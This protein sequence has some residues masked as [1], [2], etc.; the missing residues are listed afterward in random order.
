[1]P[2]DQTTTAS[3][4]TLLVVDDEPSIAKYMGLVLMREGYHVL[5]AFNAEEGWEI[6]Q[7]ATP[8]VRAVV[9][10][11]AMPGD[12]NGLELARRVR[13]ASPATPVL[14]VSGY[15]PPPSV[16]LANGLLS[17]PFTADSLRGA[18]RRMVEQA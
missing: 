13:E 11:I 9:S 14:L 8:Q 2:A 15:D 17:K 10:D 5:T 7:R 4:G 3:K 1:M 12:W 18:I 6:F 16:D